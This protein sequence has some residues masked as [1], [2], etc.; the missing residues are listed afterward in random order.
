LWSKTTLA[1]RIDDQYLLAFV[2][3]NIKR[4]AVKPGYFEIVY[5]RGDAGKQKQ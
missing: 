2:F 4:L 3:G 5:A 1:G